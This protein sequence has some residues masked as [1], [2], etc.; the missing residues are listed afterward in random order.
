MKQYNTVLTIAGSDSGGGAGIQADLKTFSACGCYGMSVITAI[1]AQN[2]QGVF[3]ISPVPLSTIEK[4]IDAVMKDIGAQ[5]VKVGMLHSSE[6]I[7]LVAKKVQQYQ[8]KNLVIDPVMVATSG[9]K[10]LQDEAIQALQEIL[11]PLARII[12]PNIPEAEILLRQRLTTQSEL[13]EAAARLSLNDTVSVLLKAGHLSD[14]KLVDVFYNAESK[15]QIFLESQRISTLNTH[16]TGCTLS[17]AIASFL[18]LDKP[19][20]QAVG[21]GKDYISSA[22]QAGKDFKLGQGHGP[23]HHFYNLWRNL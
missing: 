23:V 15:N 7:E 19:L 11:L 20:E 8:I 4:Q 3:D 21:K 10:L 9:D 14:E 13:P 2:T 22:I 17:S 6:V 5:A 18:A 16:G 12:T 1:T